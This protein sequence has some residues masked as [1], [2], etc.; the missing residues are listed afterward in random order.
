MT[1]FVSNLHL[2]GPSHHFVDASETYCFWYLIRLYFERNHHWLEWRRYFLRF[3]R[4]SHF[5]P[6]LEFL[7]LMFLTILGFLFFLNSSMGDFWHCVGWRVEFFENR[8]EVW[9]ILLSH[10]LAYTEIHSL[11]QSLWRFWFCRTLAP[12]PVNVNL[13]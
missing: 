8:S 1:C 9:M 13:N 4:K 3:W 12:W 7:L 11:I 5:W 10:K 2:N 6:F